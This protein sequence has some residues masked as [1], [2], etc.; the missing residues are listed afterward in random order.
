MRDVDIAAAGQEDVPP[1]GGEDPLDSYS[2]TVAGVVER[3]GPAVVRVE[4]QGNRRRGGVGSG[5][6]IADDGLEMLILARD[7][8]DCVA[9]ALREI[10]RKRREHRVETQH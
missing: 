3:V 6:V 7:E 10:A 8:R 9:A 4:S 1:P 5:V 2:R